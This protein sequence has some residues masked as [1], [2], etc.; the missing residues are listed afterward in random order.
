MIYII[1]YEFH[2]GIIM[3]INEYGDKPRAERSLSFLCRF[4]KEHVKELAYGSAGM[5]AYGLLMPGTMLTAM[6]VGA[7]SV[8]TGAVV[9]YMSEKHAK[10]FQPDP[11]YA[12]NPIG[13]K[14]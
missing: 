12:Y 5:L 6:S 2:E 13:R 3:N 14:M 8:A 11:E 7:T 1:W 10:E 4:V 9:K